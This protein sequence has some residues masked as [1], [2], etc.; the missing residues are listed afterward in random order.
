MK[1]VTN[2]CDFCHRETRET[3]LQVFGAE[4]VSYEACKGCIMAILRRVAK[5]KLLVLSPWCKNC[6]GTG[7]V[8]EA[9]ND[10]DHITYETKKCEACKI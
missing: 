10:Y 1:K 6:S 3:D 8:K 4:G 9:N 2:Y 7:I 5:D